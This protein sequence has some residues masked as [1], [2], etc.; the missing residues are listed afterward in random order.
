MAIDV[1]KDVGF[2]IGILIPWIIERRFIKFT[3]DGSLDCKF[4]RIA[5][6]YLGYMILMYVLYPL[7]KASLIPQMANLLNFFMFPYYVILIVPAIIKFFQN[8]K[9][10]VYE[11]NLIFFFFLLMKVIHNFNKKNSM[12]SFS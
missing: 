12:L 7:I 6:A 4:L 3:S 11:N 9:K 2:S 1:Y 5:G 10:D 8:R